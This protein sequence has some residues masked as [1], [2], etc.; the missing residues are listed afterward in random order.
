MLE[1]NDAAAAVGRLRMATSTLGPGSKRRP[2]LKVQQLPSLEGQILC[3]QRTNTPR[4]SKNRTCF[5]SATYCNILQHACGDILELV[6]SPALREV[7]LICTFGPR[8]E[9]VEVLHYFGDALWEVACFGGWRFVRTDLDVFLSFWALHWALLFVC[10]ISSNCSPVKAMGSP[11]P[12]GFVGRNKITCS[13]CCEMLQSHINSA[14]R[15]VMIAI[16]CLIL[17]SLTSRPEILEVI[18]QVTKSR[19]Q[20]LCQ[21]LFQRERKQRSIK[22]KNWK[23]RFRKLTER[24][25]RMSKKL[26]CLAHQALTSHSYVSPCLQ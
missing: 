14:T 15:Q 12:A 23:R 1:G 21:R 2:K 20:S 13:S 7:L 22:L 26:S 19:Q 18:A 8:G 5:L 11:R 25:K 16:F 9:A 10:C 3:K 6:F 17:R 4:R 24:R